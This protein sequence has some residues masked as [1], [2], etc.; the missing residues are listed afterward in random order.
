[1]AA[2]GLTGAVLWLDRIGPLAAEAEAGVLQLLSPTEQGRLARIS[3]AKRRAE[4][5]AGRLLLRRLLA[6]TLGGEARDWSLTAAEDGPPL[7]P[8]DAGVCL[9]LSHSGGWVAGAVSTSPAGLDLETPGRAR[10]VLALAANVCTPGEQARLCAL[11]GAAR[12]AAFREMWTLKEAWLKRRGDGVSPARLAAVGTR[13]GGLGAWTWVSP[14]VTL[15]WTHALGVPRWFRG[16]D[17]FGGRAPAPWGIEDSLR[18]A[19]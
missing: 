10:D 11:Q 9:A 5:L 6:A 12:D 4:F 8:A 19:Y 16:E 14:E 2:L 7:V 13:E 3:S 18:F 17:T 1:V 15:A